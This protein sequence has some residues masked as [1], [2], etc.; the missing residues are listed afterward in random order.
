[1]VDHFVEKYL[2]GIIRM[3]LTMNLIAWVEG[4]VEV[5]EDERTD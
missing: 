2:F 5:L 4:W 3:T 1:V